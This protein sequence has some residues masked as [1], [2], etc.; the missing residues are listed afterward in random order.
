[1]KQTLKLLT[2]LCLAML[3]ALVT[4]SCNAP[5]IDPNITTSDTTEVATPEEST[6]EVTTPEI[7]TP[8]VTTTSPEESTTPPEV[9]TTPPEVTT[10]PPEVTTTPPEETTTPDPLPDDS[11]ASQGLEFT[12]ND[13]GESYSVTGIGTCTDTEI[14][15]PAT[16]KDKPVTAIGECAFYGFRNLTSITIS[17]GV[18]RIDEGAFYGCR[19]LT[20]IIIPNSV[21]IIGDSVFSGCGDLESIIVASQNPTYYSDGNCLIERE[22]KTLIK[23]CKNSIIPQGVVRI[24]DSAFNS[25]IGLISI[26]I[27]EG[28][29]S[30]G[31]NVFVNCNN[32]INITI[33]ES[34][35]SIGNSVFHSCYSLTSITIPDGVTS[36]GTAVFYRCCSLTS[37]TISNRT[38]SIG[39]YAFYDCFSLTSITFEETVAQWNAINKGEKWDL[40][41]G[42]Y[43]V[44]C[45]DGTIAKD[46]TIT[47]KSE[48]QMI[49]EA[50]M[51]LNHEEFLEGV[52]TL[53]GIVTIVNNVYLEHYQNIDVTIMVDGYSFYCFHLRG[54]GVK[55]LGIGDTITVTGNIAKYNDWVEFSRYCQLDSRIPNAGGAPACE[56]DYIDGVVCRC[57]HIKETGDPEP[58]TTLTIEE[59]IELGLSKQWM[60]PTQGR[61]YVTGVIV[62]ITNTNGKHGNMYIR[63]DEG[64]TLYLYSLFNADGSKRFDVMDNQPAVGDTITVYG[65]LSQYDGQAQMINAFMV[66]RIPCEE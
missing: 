46:G 28:V 50:A 48:A 57:G 59:A 2:L 10:T 16:Y 24:G 32:L 41:T 23:G 60:K 65:A 64:N 9:T 19:G 49:Y 44:Y 55:D 3:M 34:V 40:D 56:H 43:T 18:T 36:I 62:S 14:V 26:T 61:Y 63:D 52:Y 30:I 21:T 7:T 66:D 15:I 47:Y 5:N 6:P 42:D 4:L 8:E 11:E 31:D 45:L 53:T 58:D 39:E 37:I 25:C 17:D 13:D 33:P 22:S 38:T 51:R 20:S 54:D 12:L 35:T 29:T 27:P 1:M